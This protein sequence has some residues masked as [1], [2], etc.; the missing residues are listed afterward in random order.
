MKYAQT[1]IVLTAAFFSP[2]AACQEKGEALLT[3][4]VSDEH[5]KPVENA[6]VN[7]IYFDH[8]KPG[9]GFG[10]DVYGHVEQKTDA[11]G[12]S[13]LR[14]SSAR[15]GFV[16]DIQA[17]GYYKGSGGV[18]FG[19]GFKPGVG[20]VK[21][22]PKNGRWEPWNPT[23]KVELRKKIYPIPLIAR[24]FPQ[25]TEYAKIP[26]FGKPVGFDLEV[27]DWVAPHGKGKTADLIFQLSGQ[28]PK[29]GSRLYDVRLTVAFSN[30]EDGFVVY[31]TSKH[32]QGY[33]ELRLP[34]RAPPKDGYQKTYVKRMAV[35][36]HIATQE[37]HEIA[38][39]LR[40]DG[41]PPLEA[42]TD[43]IEEINPHENLFL[44]VRT[45]VNK[46]G[47]IVS[48]NYAKMHGGY[49]QGGTFKWYETGEIHFTYYFNPTPNDT[50]LEFDPKQNLWKGDGRD[51]REP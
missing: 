37:D 31:D 17:N 2:L 43:R 36:E 6:M 11:K 49:G 18:N 46:K 3:Y 21:P 41:L 27:S 9:E 13:I 15:P 32:S 23:V 24:H 30:P 35:L 16:A 19:T 4:Q 12:V 45:K 42:G 25:D 14:A 28:S 48:A 44:R 51:V 29:P 47:E 1:V 38:E 20:G 22:I 10:Q 34:H 50:N 40:A 26:A 5:G 8:W 39:R 7:L 33:S